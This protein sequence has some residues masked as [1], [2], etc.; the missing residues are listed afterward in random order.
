MFGFN[1]F[2]ISFNLRLGLFFFLSSLPVDALGKNLWA[3][4]LV[5]GE[6]LSYS[7]LG[8]DPSDPLTH[9]NLL[10]V[11][12][13]YLSKATD[14]SQNND[15]R[16]SITY[17][18]SCIELATKHDLVKPLAEAFRLLGVNYDKLSLYDR[19]LTYFFQSLQSYERLDDQ[20]GIAENFNAIG[21]VYGYTRDFENGLAYLHRALEFNDRLGNEKGKMTSYLNIG[22]IHQK[23]R[24]FEE[25]LSFYGQALEI[26]VTLGN[27]EIEAVA[28]GNIGS[29]R[30]QQGHP[31]LGLAFLENALELKEQNGD[32]RRTL[33]TLNDIA[34]ARLLLG[35][36]EE[37]RQ[38]A[39]KVVELAKDY[40]EGNQLRYAYLNLSRSYSQSEDYE[41][42]YIYL[43]RFDEVKDSLFGIEKT[44]LINALQ[45]AY[46]TEKKDQA[47][48]SLQQ[49][50]ELAN[51][52]KKIY[53]LTGI[54]VVMIMG[55]LYLHLHF[56]NRRNK[57]L[58]EKEKEVDKLKTNFFANI[59]HE[60]RTPLTL[61]LSPIED[62][63]AHTDDSDQQ[64]QLALMKKNGTRILRL[65][66]QILELS[67][68]ESGKLKLSVQQS[69]I[70]PVLAGVTASFESLAVS[71]NIDLA[72]E[73]PGQPLQL[74]FN[75]DQIE[76]VLINLIS[77]AI[78]FSDE[79]GK[80][81]VSV[82][83]I[84]REMDHADM[85]QIKV[86]D[87]GR[88]L[89]PD[90]VRHIF[91]RFYQAGHADV[92]YFGGTGIGLAL[93]KEL[94]EL[95]K[96]SI[97]VESQLKI[98]TEISVL[99]P[100][101]MGH[102]ADSQIDADHEIKDLHGLEDIDGP[103][104]LSETTV[105]TGLRKP[106]V[107]LIEDNEELRDYIKSIFRSTYRV[108]E[109]GNGEEGVL[110][111]KEKIPDLVI[112][113]VM[114]PK[115]DGYEAC[116]Q[117]KQSE[118]TSHIPVILLTAKGSVASRIK[119]HETE[120]DLYLSKPFVPKELLICAQ[121]LIRSRKKLRER[122]NKQVVLKPSDI[123]V[124]SVD[125][126]FLERLLTVVEVNF[127]DEGFSVEQLGREMGMSRSQLHRKLDALT[128]ESCSQFIRTFRLQRAMDL[129]K[130][131]HA[132]ISE[133]AFMVGFGS[134]SY[135]NRCFLKHYGRPPSAFIASRVDV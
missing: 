112:S 74:Y 127:H 10:K 69:D 55:G 105:G 33:H 6:R 114:M 12:E 41:K 45:I 128:N 44:Q 78:K 62:L 88:G 57:V 3:E 93:T 72:F 27:K 122:Y 77:N 21:K 47:I 117:L 49:E 46:E 34:E 125:E 101:G 31:Q 132:S 43:E 7:H 50:K 37:A 133:I 67:K 42:A 39:G 100:M 56:N 108:L 1:V 22:V 83:R 16:H 30:M 130:S 129:L 87:E 23:K 115:M 51:S 60:F 121:N 110:I 76:T 116:R 81:L 120:A 107:L 73:S 95:H 113:D 82:E 75:T 11:V 15:L 38:A 134:P 4:N 99:L 65:V 61:I 89:P 35:D 18:D 48:T 66:N 54:I 25:A 123:A 80:I 119:G 94:V 109:A 24:D 91:D 70:I 8:T 29:T 79:G 53:L 19:A 20:E 59:S 5:A 64:Y 103:L 102:L 13:A 131:R 14:Y 28:I 52:Q 85:L 98:G 126:I 71:K 17:L 63:L 104:V 58:L 124:N 111:A 9:Q 2:F 97:S 68:L 40:E 90:K 84:Q 86:K 32:E 96:G 92:S 118:S 135:F 26:A 36:W 106:I